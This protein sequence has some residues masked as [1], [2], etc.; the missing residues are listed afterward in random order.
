MMRFSYLLFKFLS[1]FTVS[2]LAGSC[3]SALGVF[4]YLSPTLPNAEKLKDVKLQTPLRIY[5]HDGQLITEFGEKRRRPIKID[6]VPPEFI[7]ALLAS[8]DSNFYSHN[9]IDYKG[10]TR[11]VVQ[12]VTTGR[13]KGGGSTISMQVARNYYLSKQKTFK[14]KFTEILLTFKIEELLTKQEILELYIN[15]VFLGKRAYGFEAASQVY[16]G[17]HLNELTLAQLAMLAGLPQAPSAAN[18]INNP[19]RAM[20]R[21]NYV[22]ARMRTLDMISLE[23][24]ERAAIQPVTA[25]FH[26]L[27]TQV[28]APYV[29]EMIRQTMVEQ[30]GDDIYT[31]GY[32]VYTTIDA[33]RQR[34]A[35][36]A[37]QRGLL[38]YSRDHGFRTT[39]NV[40][41]P[42]VPASAPASQPSETQEEDGSNLNAAMSIEAQEIVVPDS[43]LTNIDWQQTFKEWQTYLL[44]QPA[45]GIISPAIV[46]SV[47]DQPTTKADSKDIDPSDDAGAWLYQDNRLIWLPLSAMQW[48]KPKLSVD[49]VGEVPTKPSQILSVGQVVWFEGDPDQRIELAQKPEVQ[50][51][52]VSL[53]PDNGAVQALVGGFAFN[54]GKFN[55]AVQAKRQPG[56]AFKPFI[57]STALNEGFTP[58]TLINDAPVVFDDAELENTWRPQN[59]SG[60]FYGPTRLRQA[61]Y[62][63]QNLVSI[64]VLKRIKPKTVIKFVEP[65]GFDPNTLNKDLSLALGASAMTP[66]TLAQGYTVFAN[67]GFAVKSFMIDRIALDDDILFEATPDTVCRECEQSPT[68]TPQAD[69]A[70]LAIND[71]TA[72]DDQPELPKAKRVMDTRVNYL[73]TSMM[74]DVIKRGTGK[75]AL[76]LNRS[77]LA[78]KTGTTNDQKDG[79]FSGFGGGLVTTVWVGF[80]EHKT[81]G[82]WAFGGTTALPIW[83]DY[84][85][86]A[87]AGVPELNLPRPAG[88]VS[89]RIDPETG[90]LAY[91][92]QPNA[93]FEV[94][95][96]ENVPQ[97]A[98][99]APIQESFYQEDGEA[100]QA[101]N[102][103]LT[104]EQLF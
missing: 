18:P 85:R 35:N 104:P 38:K 90:D 78:G 28:D 94:F 19:E 1:W 11:A 45:A 51:A 10:L 99:Q 71:L 17:K 95:R 61:L 100:P 103:D 20:N 43:D 42:L 82:R 34:A 40:I 97:N 6:D 60:K 89:V 26:S 32:R 8:E 76:A 5:T 88:I 68:E 77:D 91:P 55:H 49:S 7:N 47:R 84:M 65:F 69:D 63:S 79:W 15:K 73:I 66:W 62:K 13:K 29:A 27:S 58:A 80:D 39:G 23:E 9:G 21:R 53:N 14:R 16:Y 2:I 59:H 50:G 98:T 74:K 31:E 30:Y 37:M 101:T 72:Q 4:L 64:R 86:E 56:S 75:R 54:L 24:F 102:D 48:A 22:L 70:L 87:L 57:Y 12:L 44:R 96:E 67:G 25:K 93:I 81:L 3:I 52:L 36:L 83:V 46:A 92:G 41:L 33:S